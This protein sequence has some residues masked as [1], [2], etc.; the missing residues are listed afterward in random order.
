[1]STTTIVARGA[2]NTGNGYTKHGQRIGWVRLD[3][4]AIVFSDIDRQIDGAV[5]PTDADHLRTDQ[6]RVWWSY[7]L[8]P[9]LSY[10][11][12]ARAGLDYDQFNTLREFSRIEA[13]RA[14][15]L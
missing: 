11:D 3:T 9:A 4:G 5:A 7:Y 2:W 10:W 8:N 15:S 13:G 12:K 6:E 1:M 14:R